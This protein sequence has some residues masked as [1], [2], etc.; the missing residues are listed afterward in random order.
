MNP[1]LNSDLQNLDT[2]MNDQISSNNVHF[3]EDF[4]SKGGHK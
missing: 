3:S 1:V 2:S 4:K